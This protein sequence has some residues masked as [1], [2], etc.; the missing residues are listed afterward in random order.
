MDQLLCLRSFLATVRCGNFS[1]AAREMNTVPSVISKRINYLEWSL[2]VKLFER[3][4]RQMALTH[5]GSR[6]HAQAAR[7]LNDFD[8]VQDLFRQEEPAMA[9]QLKL[10]ASTSLGL[11]LLADVI[12]VF[13]QDH[14]QVQID[15]MLVDRPVNPLEEGLDISLAGRT[16][17]YEG[18]V[19]IPLR[20]LE[21]FLC[22]SPDYLSR[23]GSPSHPRDL[24]GHRTLVFNP[25]GGLWTFDS[26]HG[27]LR[28]E[29]RPSVSSNDNTVLTKVALAG[30]GIAVLPAYAVRDAFRSGSL[31]PLLPAYPLQ[32]AWIKAQVPETRLALLRVQAMLEALRQGLG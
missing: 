15:L 28:V 11:N 29:V 5:E 25:T 17:S 13:Q 3:S 4:S 7:L 12:G 10:R 24:T 8:A 18:V 14:P 21:Q 23:H 9:G 19:D 30:A 20:P 22:A 32:R 31:Q 2:G 6:L 1:A 16:D 27:V 26:E